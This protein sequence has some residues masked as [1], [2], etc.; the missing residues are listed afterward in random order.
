MNW[1]VGKIAQALAVPAPSAVAPQRIA[2]FSIDSR[3]LKP[4]E[5]FLALRG[6]RHDG[7][8]FVEEAFDRG[9]VAAV[10]SQAY[11]QTQSA[12]R[13]KKLV[14]V[15][16]TFQALQELARFARRTW[17]RS[18][19]ALTGSTG[20][21]TTKEMLAALLATRYRVL[22]SEGN[23]NNEYGLPLTLLR[24]QPDTHLAVVEM[25]MTRQGEIAKLCAVAEPNLGL[26]TNVNPV[27]LEFFASLDDIAEAKRELL[28]ALATPATAV[29]NADDTRVRCFADGFTGQVVFFGFAADADVRAEKVTDRGCDGTEFDLCASDQRRRVRLPLIGRH[30]IS[31]ALAAYAAASRFEIEIGTAA[32]V[33]ARMEPASLRGQRLRFSAPGGG[34]FSVINDTY[35]ANPRAVLAVAEAVSRTPG[36]KRRLLVLGEMRELGPTGPALHREVGEGIVAL[37]NIDWLVGVTGLAAELVAGARAAGLPAHRAVFFEKKEAAADWL[38]ENARDGDLILLKA[39]R[40]LALETLLDAFCAKFPLEV[41]SAVKAAL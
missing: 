6:P 2:G 17:G 31:N 37:G 23:L 26:V 39:S 38:C 18:V 11:C 32:E 41:G 36:V 7:H 9:A 5:V 40:A 3:T 29:L 22:K 35:N 34:E 33:F 21:T 4:G 19:L 25:A 20:K 13:G 16:D 1:T 10:V 28:R 12:D 8:N 24:L 15:T 14:A 30:N 27:H